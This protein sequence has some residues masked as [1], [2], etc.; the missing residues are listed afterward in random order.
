MSA[1]KRLLPTGAR[2]LL[3]IAAKRLLPTDPASV[4]AMTSAVTWI[5]FTRRDGG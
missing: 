3:P 1:A 5:S 2:E 4:E